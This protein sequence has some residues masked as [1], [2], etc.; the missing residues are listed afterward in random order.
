MSDPSTPG[1]PV[2]AGPPAAEPRPKSLTVRGA[3]VLGI[4]SMIGAGIFALL[5]EA[6]AVAGAAC[7]S[8]S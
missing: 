2:E 6:G 5:G 8:R 4:G 7:G 1:Q 3:T